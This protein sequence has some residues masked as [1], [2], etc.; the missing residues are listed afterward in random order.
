MSRI[1]SAG[2][3]IFFKAEKYQYLH[4]HTVDMS[5]CP[6]PHF[7]MGLILEGSG[8]FTDCMEKREIVIQPGDIIFVPISS[9]YISRWSGDPKVSYISMHFIFDN[10][11]IFSRHKNFELQKIRVK[12]FDQAKELFQTVLENYNRGESEILGVLG[13]FYEVLAEILPQLQTKQKQSIDGRINATIEYI[14][15]H[16]AENLSVVELANAGNMSVS[17]F[18]PCFKKS[19]GVTPT[20]YINHYRISRAIILMMNDPNLPIEVIGERVGFESSAYFR[21]TFK[22]ITGRTPRD[23]RQISMEI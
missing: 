4:N 20:D 13:K 23:Y 22:K 7:C 19:L 6:R 16:Y 10:P 9:R 15:Q 21:R 18:Y 11:S 14:E 5:D 1:T 3:L 8:V 17:R 2:N 12:D